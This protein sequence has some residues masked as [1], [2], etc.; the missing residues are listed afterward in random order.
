MMNQAS[1]GLKDVLARLIEN[2]V[3]KIEFLLFFF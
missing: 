3:G 2:L 1:Y